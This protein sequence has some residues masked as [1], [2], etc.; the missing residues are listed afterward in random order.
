M[1]AFGRYFDKPGDNNLRGILV[2]YYDEEV[3]PDSVVRREHKY[4]F[5]IPVYVKDTIE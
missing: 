3:A 1:V 2:E 5:D 4:Y